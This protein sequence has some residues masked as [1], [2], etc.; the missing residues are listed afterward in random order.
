MKQYLNKAFGLFFVL[1]VVFIPFVYTSLQLQV[2]GFVFK[3][4]VQFLG[5]LFYSRP[6]TLIDF[7]SDTRSLLLLLILLA[8]TAGITAIFIKRKQPGIIWACKTIVLYFLAY[9]FLKY[10][11]D[12]VFGLQF[13]TPAPNILYTPFGNLDKDILFWSTMGTSPAYSIF[14]GMVEVVAALLLLSR[15]TRTVGLMLIEVLTSGLYMRTPAE[16]TG[17][18]KVEQYTVNGIITDSCQRP[19]KRI[20][21][22]PKQYFILQSPQDT[23]TDFH[24]TADYKKQQLTLTGYD[25]TRHK[26]DYE[27]HGDTLV[28]NFL[29]FWLDSL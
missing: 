12:K 23:M 24:F 29:K 14:T 26:I 10:G 3:A 4:P 5:G 20:F 7:S 1:C 17:A 2:T 25:G 9:V 16:L 6:I 21:I 13:Y 18:Y 11:F 27:K 28:F 8:V 22:H 15:R 19:V